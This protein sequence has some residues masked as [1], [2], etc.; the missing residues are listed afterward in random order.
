MKIDLHTHTKKCKSGDAPTREIAAADFCQT[1]TATE[2]GVIAITNHNVFDLSQFNEI[3]GGLSD[4]VQVWPG[5]EIDVVESGVRGH[6]LVIVSPSRAVEFSQ[7]VEKITEG[8]TP[9]DFTTTIEDVL[10]NFEAFKPIYVAHYKQKTPN[11][12]DEALEILIHGTASPGRVIKEVYQF[13]FRRYLHLP[14]IRIY[15]RF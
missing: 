10:N 9:D 13:D 5:I 3:L 6:V 14:W 2:V 7:V 4:G 8:S 11:I 12:S 1:I 15:L